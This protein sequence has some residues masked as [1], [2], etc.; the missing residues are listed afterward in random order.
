MTGAADRTFAGRVAA[1]AWLGA[2]PALAAEARRLEATAGADHRELPRRAVELA[3]PGPIDPFRVARH[4]TAA[5]VSRMLRVATNLPGAVASRRPLN[6]PGGW[7]RDTAVEA[8]VDQLALAGPAGAEL[9]R[10]IEGGGAL[11][12]EPLRRELARRRIRPLDVTPDVV[13]ALLERAFPA[14]VHPDPGEP[15]V[16]LLDPVPLTGTPVA[17]LHRARLL[18][19]TTG[20]SVERPVLV[21]ARRPRVAR[22]LL[23]DARLAAG[24]TAVLQRVAADLAEP[25]T[26]APGAVPGAWLGVGATSFVRLALRAHLDAVDQRFEALGLIELG[27]VAEELDAPVTV[28]RPVPGL[29]EERA[30]VIEDLDGVPLTR[31]AA[32]L[33][34]PDG[35]VRAVVALT[36]EAALVHGV[37]W[38]DPA[39][40]HLLV[41]PDGTLALVGVG[42][43]GRLTPD[44]LLAGV[45]TLRAVLTG[46][47]AA[48][49]EGL[50]R[51]GAVGPDVDT[52]A[53][54]ADLARTVRID[55]MQLLMGGAQ[56]LQGAL[57]SLVG[58]LLAH[59]LEPPV[60]VMLLLRTIFAAGR[61]VGLLTPG[62]GPG[63]MGALLPL[64]PR[65]P[66]LLA[67][68][69][70]GAAA[71]ADPAEAAEPGEPDY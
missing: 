61:L 33:T 36:I 20:A 22:D 14:S 58:T 16:R 19:G 3:Q 51:V 65:L 54:V 25:E 17:Q 70:A 59:R 45:R 12:P 47:H 44:L 30:V 29:S 46:D 40:E 21:R 10:F 23:N 43:L 39:P 52:D 11:F 49:V 34:D 62:D 24:A 7:M 56:G 64:L 2:D 42:V 4:A 5:S 50:R 48:M 57:N 15:V 35:A 71:A 27:L 28:A 31:G 18:R 6:D 26:G 53:L 37:F 63:L 69:E 55:P 13:Q 32:A 68:A 9:A 66:D 67:A 38:A 8:F 60:E 1:S 41:R